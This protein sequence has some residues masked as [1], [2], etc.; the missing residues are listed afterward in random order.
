MLKRQGLPFRGMQIFLLVL[1]GTGCMSAGC[2]ATFQKPRSP[3]LKGGFPLVL[4]HSGF[5]SLSPTESGVCKSPN[6]SKRKQAPAQAI[7]QVLASCCYCATGP[8]KS[9]RQSQSPCGRR[10]HQSIDTERRTVVA[11]LF[12][13]FLQTMYYL[14]PPYHLSCHDEKIHMS[15]SLVWQF[16]SVTQSCLTL[17]PH[18]PQHTRPPCPS[19]TP[20][21]NPNSC[22]L[23]K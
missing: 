19:P 9:H 3:S 18:G 8:S 2:H 17:R 15:L 5:H 6:S 21:V 4:C 10:Q 1:T 23:S 7:V 22:P 11:V 16:S 14:Y 13:F 12:G 20:R